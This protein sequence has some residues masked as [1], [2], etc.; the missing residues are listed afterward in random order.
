M[1]MAPTSGVYVQVTPLQEGSGLE[2]AEVVPPLFLAEVDDPAQRYVLHLKVRTVAGRKPEVVE[3][4]L[5]ARATPDADRITTEGLRGVHVAKALELAV[6]RARQDIGDR[7][8]PKAPLA[9]PQRGVPISHTFLQQVT[10]IYRAAVAAGSRSPVNQVAEQ[11]G[12]SRSTAGR[13]VVQ[14][15]RAKLLRPAMGTRAGEAMPART[16]A[17]RRTASAVSSPSALAGR[18]T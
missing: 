6:N 9:R 15:R 10:D 12:T 4:G 2:K 14:A 11:L 5:E 1:V 17:R 3:L 8:T 18:A 7:R 13:W 16:P